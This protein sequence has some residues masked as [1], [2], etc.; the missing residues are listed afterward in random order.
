MLDDGIESKQS[1]ETESTIHTSVLL[2][3]VIETLSIEAD[4]LVIDATLGGGGHAREIILRLENDGVYIGID[5]DQGA[6][7][8]FAKVCPE[9]KAQVLLV[10]ENFRNIAKVLETT[11]YHSI[12]KALFDLG[13]SS[14]QLDVSHRGFS[15]L[16]EEP[17]Q[18]TLA[19]ESSPGS[20]TAYDVVNEWTE[21]QLQMIIA[22]Y[23]EES[24]AKRIAQRI[25]EKRAEA[26]IA[27]TT[28]LAQLISEAIPK[29]FH[30]RGHH[31][32]TKTF[33]AIRIAVN[34]ELS[35]L[36][37]GLEGA[38][39]ALVPQGRMVVISFHSLEDRIVKRFFH[40]Q[41]ATGMAR[42]LMKKPLTPQAEELHDNPRSRSAKLRAIE[43]N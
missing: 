18:M 37:E 25:V 29:R 27:T 36:S 13:L 41:V 35:A 12:T 9:T 10:R 21:N 7:D 40:E 30:K 24:W 22:G 23:G 43:K 20:V 28:Q 6:L 2:H 38:W 3:E 42:L 4:D 15:F 1:R 26:P 11:G 14:D 5:A 16:R 19:E 8:R 31:P 17:L 39:Q 32:A 33:Q 34:D